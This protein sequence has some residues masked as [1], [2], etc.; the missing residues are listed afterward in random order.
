MTGWGGWCPEP[1]APLP[2]PNHV[3]QVGYETALSVARL[4]AIGIE[5][6]LALGQPAS[7]VP[8]KAKIKKI[9]IIKKNGAELSYHEPPTFLR[10]S[11]SGVHVYE[12]RVLL[13][14]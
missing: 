3:C 1:G 9:I 12:K 6:N 8:T 13:V 2:S 4:I 14:I 10:I 7:P 11:L 5:P